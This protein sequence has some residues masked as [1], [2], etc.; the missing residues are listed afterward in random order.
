MISI[1]TIEHVLTRSLAIV[2]VLLIVALASGVGNAQQVDPRTGQPVRDQDDRPKT[3]EE[4]LEK[5][6]IEK[7][8]KDHD[9]MVSRGEE[10]MK[11]SEE[12][13]K[14][15]E[16]HGKL[17]GNDY[18]KMASMEKLVKKIRDELGGGDDS[19]DDDDDAQAKLSSTRV[20][21]KTLKD[22]TC[23]MFDELKKTTRFSISLS[24]IQTTNTVL[25]IVRLLKGN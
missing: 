20:G 2:L 7:D 4:T 21:M 11:I 16:Q 17:S 8:K 5:M 3:I 10:V 13:E 1:A 22:S 18:A 9:Q 6:R 19:D 12:L 23:A 15:Y 25:R 24:A 14:S